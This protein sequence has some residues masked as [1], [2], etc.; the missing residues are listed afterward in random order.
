MLVSQLLLKTLKD[1]SRHDLKRFKWYLA[2]NNLKNCKRV[3]LCHLVSPHRRDTVSKMIDSYGEEKAVSLTIAILKKMEHNS[4]AE[5]LEKTYAEGAAAQEKVSHADVTSASSSA[6]DLPADQKIST[7]GATGAITPRASNATNDSMNISGNV[8]R[9]AGSTVISN[10]SMA[11]SGN[12]HRNVGSIVS[13]NARMTVSGNALKNAGCIGGRNVGS[14]DS[15]NFIGHV[16][17]TITDGSVVIS[18]NACENVEDDIGRVAVRNGDVIISGNIVGDIAGD[19]S[20]II[21]RNGKVIINGDIRGNVGPI[22]GCKSVLV[23]SGNVRGNVW[24]NRRVIVSGNVREGAAAQEK[25]SHSL[26]TSSCALGLPTAQRSSTDGAAGA[27]AMKAP[28]APNACYGGVIVSRNVGGSD[29][30]QFCIDD[31]Y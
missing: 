11:V 9:N 19:V 30:S 23:I 28:N 20:D 8:C 24:G 21:G 3:P 15:M 16:F 6:L 14:I 5:E 2:L 4:A 29:C 17:A 13:S 18:N 7:D 26:V 25:V 31:E 22:V 10:D 1:L 12:V 27:I